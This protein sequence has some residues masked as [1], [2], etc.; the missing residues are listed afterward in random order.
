MAQYFFDL[1]SSDGSALDDEGME[2]PDAQAAHAVAIDALLSA[3]RESVIEGSVDQNFAVHVR[4]DAGPVLEVA[5]TFRSQIFR[6][7]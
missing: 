5:A 2:L 1:K 3:A 6:T 4:D 7:Q